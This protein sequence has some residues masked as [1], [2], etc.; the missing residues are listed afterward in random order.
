MINNFFQY[1]IIYVSLDVLMV[2]QRIQIFD[3]FLFSNYSYMYFLCQTKNKFVVNNMPVIY[4]SLT[5]DWTALEQNDETFPGPMRSFIVNIETLPVQWLAR[6][7]RISCLPKFCS[8][9][10]KVPFM[11]CNIF[12]F[13]VELDVYFCNCNNVI[14]LVKRYEYVIKYRKIM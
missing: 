12:F 11:F 4:T 7:F 14:L 6:S 5:F 10:F 1:S 13:C 3:I 8:C 9:S 2:W